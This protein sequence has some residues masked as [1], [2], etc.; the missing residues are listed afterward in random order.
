ME[1]KKKWH[2]SNQTMTYPFSFATLAKTREAQLHRK[3]NLKNEKKK[4]KK[5][6]EKKKGVLNMPL[7]FIFN[8]A[9]TFT[10]QSNKLNQ[11]QPT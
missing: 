10:H 5:E 1:K 3:D 7:V 11:T 9:C 2:L 8:Y 4:K 6:K